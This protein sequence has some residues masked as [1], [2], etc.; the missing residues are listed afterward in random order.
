M[1]RA[2]GEL[3]QCRGL[4]HIRG[5]TNTMPL[6]VEIC[7]TNTS[8]STAFAVAS[9]LALLALTT[10]A[11]KT[12][13]E[14]RAR[15]QLAESLPGAKRGKSYEHRSE[16][17]H[18]KF[19]ICALDHVDLNIPSGELV[20]LLGPSGSGRPRFAHYAGLEFADLGTILFDGED[21]THRNARDRRVGFVFQH[22]A[23]F[24]HMTVF[25]TSLSTQSPPSECASVEGADPR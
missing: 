8:F 20:A 1:P 19:D 6:H 9:L 24:R 14:W 21:T 3:A 23:L 17:H 25:E 10:L 5:R 15:R 22:Y 13:V 7:T 18:K 4:G 2:M 12:V 11:V 16:R